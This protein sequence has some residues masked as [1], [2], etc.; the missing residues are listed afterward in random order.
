MNSLLLI[1]GVLA[2]FMVAGHCTMG[3]KQ[4]FLPMLAA[5]FD[6]TS[7]RIMAF[8]WHMSTVTL[9]LATAVLFYSALMPGDGAVRNALALYIAAQ[10]LCYGAVHLLLVASSGLSG[11]IY[12]QFQWSLFLA[13]G[14]AAA[15]GA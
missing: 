6:P 4:F 3:R 11:A 15:A 12:K 5:A 7:K 14:I 2:A 1:S 9:V 8:V 10:F 13:V